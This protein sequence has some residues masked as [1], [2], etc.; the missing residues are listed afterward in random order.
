[1]SSTCV[2]EIPVLANAMN[3]ADPSYAALSCAPIPE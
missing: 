1:M 3:G 2:A